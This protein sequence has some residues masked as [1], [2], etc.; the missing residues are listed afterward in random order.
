[1]E[2][3]QKEFVSEFDNLIEKFE[4]ESNGALELS[5]RI[6][7]LVGNILPFGEPEPSPSEIISVKPGIIGM[8]SSQIDNVRKANL[9][10]E[11]TLKH[12]QKIA[13]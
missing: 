6:M 5:S 11:T 7:D 2:K 12:L 13:G 3:N 4:I 10:L 9:M 8:I 1:M